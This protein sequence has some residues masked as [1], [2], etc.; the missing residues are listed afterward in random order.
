MPFS[1]RDQKI[2]AWMN[3]PNEPVDDFG[4][5][6]LFIVGITIFNVKDV[7]DVPACSARGW[8]RA[9]RYIEHVG[10]NCCDDF[11][12]RVP[13]DAMLLDQ[14]RVEPPRG[15]VIRSAEAYAVAGLIS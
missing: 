15:R 3:I 1:L 7:C 2:V 12:E 14:R 4:A 9:R 5:R 10:R 13:S 8:S 11:S 6:P